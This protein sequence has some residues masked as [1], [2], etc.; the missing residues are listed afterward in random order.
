M[1]YVI[2]PWVFYIIFLVNNLR[3]WAL[4]IDVILA[5]IL[6]FCFLGDE[7]NT[8]ERIKLAKKGVIICI[9]C[10]VITVVIPDRDTC[11]KMLIASQV[12]TENI[13]NAKETVREVADYIVS[14]VEDISGDSDD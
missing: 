2:N 10:S 12:T 4:W 14:I 11:Y 8:D 9:A 6:V 3:T 7:I 13:N 5:I 1:S